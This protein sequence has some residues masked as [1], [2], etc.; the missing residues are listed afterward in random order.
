MN[1]AKNAIQMKLMAHS[2]MSPSTLGK[3]ISCPEFVSGPSTTDAQR[4]TLLHKVMETGEG[5]DQ[6]SEYDQ[7]QIDITHR[8]VNELC[9]M[10][11][12][13]GID[14]VEDLREQKLDTGIDDVWGTLDRSLIDIE[15][16]K[17]LA[18]D[19]K[20]GVNQVEPAKSNFQSIC[21]TLALFR[22]Y[23]FVTEITFAF[24]HPA[25][26]E[27]SGINAGVFEQSEVPAMDEMIANE[28]KDIQFRDTLSPSPK[29]CKYCDKLLSCAAVKAKINILLE[30]G[31]EN[32]TITDDLIDAAKLAQDKAKLI[33]EL[34]RKQMEE[35]GVEFERYRMIDVRRTTSQV[36]LGDLDDAPFDINEDVIKNIPLRMKQLE[37]IIQSDTHCI[38]PYFENLGLITFQNTK[39]MRGKSI[40]KSKIRKAE[41]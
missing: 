29:V 39:Q 25:L 31:N 13:K 30:N 18:V 22:K 38:V 35:E 2:P 5:Y 21:Y 1:N 20:F 15:N 16:K 6:L 34:A 27:S 12:R 8:R 26:E 28:V 10:Y 41:K 14:E 36:T 9:D 11:L 32:Q 33:L 37:E 17:I 23:P 24:V 4:G 19:Y 3:L 40:A 7:E